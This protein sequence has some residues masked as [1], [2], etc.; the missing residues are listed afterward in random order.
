MPAL[1]TLGRL[2]AGRVCATATLALGALALSSAAVAAD[3]CRAAKDELAALQQDSLFTQPYIDVDE[4]RNTPVRHRYVHG[5][6]IGTQTR[7]SYYL[8]PETRYDGRFFQ[9]IT[10]VPDNEY[11]SQGATGEEDRIGFAI[12]SGAY[13]IETNGGGWENM[14]GPGLPADRTIAGYR[15]NAAAARYSRIV[16]MQMYGCERPFGYTYGGS[17]GGYRTIGGMEN[18]SGV[19]DGA[20]PFVIGS[21]MAA[22]NVFTVRMYALRVLADKLPAIADAVDV[23]SGVDVRS[24]LTDEE[25][26]AFA[27][28]TAMGFPRAAW[29]AHKSLNLHGYALLFPTVLGQDPQYFAED[30]WHKPGYEGYRPPASLT[31]ALIDHSTKVK[32]VITAR[33]TAQAAAQKAKQS[34][35]RAD[36]AFE[37]MLK[38]QGA[39]R[40]VA[41][42]LDSLPVQDLL[43]AQITVTSGAAQGAR[44]LV[45]HF[46]GDTVQLRS[47]AGA[48]AGLKAG[49]T[50]H[51]DNRD[52]L[53]SQTYHRHQVPDAGYPVYDVLRDARG[54]AL[55]PQHRPL[56]APQFAAGAA[57]SVPTGKF[58]GKMIVLSNLHDTEA[59]PWQGDWYLQAA[60]E[61]LGDALNDR[62]RLWYTD[63]ATHGDHMTLQ[64]PTQTVS[65]LG[66]LQQALR[67]VSAWVEEGIAPPATSGY[68][69]EGGQVYLEDSAAARGGIQPVV[70]VR[71][72]GAARA[73]VA[74]G[75]TVTLTATVDVPPGAGEVVALAWDFGG[76]TPFPDTQVIA[77]GDRRSPRPATTHRFD[78]PGTYFVTLRAEVQRDGDTATPFTRIRNLGRARVVVR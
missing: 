7:F 24:L 53:A 22:P 74:A 34:G 78:T 59:Y 3:D 44:I 65:Y 28:V 40:P 43:G 2:A 39:Q 76:D 30:F 63:R 20:V 36:D 41:L 1:H 37:A 71:A 51:I 54:K 68:R 67:D 13:F 15:A 61:H 49:D 32:R 55:Y 45:S 9:Y 58:A 27:E 12:D 23:G 52:Y 8:P 5:G 50:L 19:W 18:T 33:D 11:L 4:W 62:L 35:G 75:D 57:G 31:A 10:P 6:F 17:G 69:I 29:Y 25:A 56:L 70:A 46:D 16:A 64:Q 77:E 66:V 38:A 14:A 73:E 21:P 42:Q 60:R 72:N 47:S 26:A 48:L